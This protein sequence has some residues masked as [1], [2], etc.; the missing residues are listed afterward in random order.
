MMF[1]QHKIFRETSY[2]WNIISKTLEA[3]RELSRA[4]SK[5]DE[6]EARRK[7]PKLDENP[8]FGIMEVFDEAEGSG[9]IY[10]QG[11]SSD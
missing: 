6:I 5:H 2:Q 10:G 9:N 11:Q 7:N 4:G 1:L 8:K 3:G